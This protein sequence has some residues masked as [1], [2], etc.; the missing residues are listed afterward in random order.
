[1]EGWTKPETDGALQK[2]VQSYKQLEGRN[3]IKSI[4]ILKTQNAGVTS[5]TMVA[6]VSSTKVDGTMIT[7]KPDFSLTSMSRLEDLEMLHSMVHEVMMEM[8][9]ELRKIE[10]QDVEGGE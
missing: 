3:I 7:I 2:Q 10:A 4:D 8:K 6:K 1:M 9:R 5:I